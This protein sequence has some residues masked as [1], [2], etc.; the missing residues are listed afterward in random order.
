MSRPENFIQK[1]NNT[2]SDESKIISKQLYGKRKFAVLN[3]MTKKELIED[4]DQNQ[5]FGHLIKKN[6]T[7]ENIIKI[8]HRYSGFI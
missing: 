3:S 5:Y 7:K 6:D 4:F 2:Y 8:L 1:Y